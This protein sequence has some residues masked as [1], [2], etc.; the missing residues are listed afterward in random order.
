MTTNIYKSKKTKTMKKCF[1]L[2]AICAMT[3]NA[4]AQK[5][6]VLDSKL[7]D[8]WFVGIYGGESF[9]T[10][11]TSVFNNLN[12]VAGLRLG[13]YI[14]PVYGLAVDGTVYFDAAPD[15]HYVNNTNTFVK[16]TNISL[17]NNFN[18][19][20]L[21]CG[22]KGTPRF[23]EVVAF[24]G[25]G[26]GHGYTSGAAVYTHYSYNEAYQPVTTKRYQRN[27]DYNALTTKFGFDFNLNLGEAKA[28]QINIEPALTYAICADD[29]TNSALAKVDGV[30]A[31]KN[32][33]A[34][35]LNKSALSLTA[36]ITYKF[37]NS[38][39][40]HNF[41]LGTLRDQAEIDGLNAR[42]NDL[43]GQV[44]TKDNEISND[45][46]AINDLKRQLQDCEN[47]AP[48]KEV[49]TKE[50]LESVVTFKQGKT[51]IEVSQQPNVERIATYLKNHKD[52]KVVIKGYASPEGAKELNEKLASQRADAVKDMLVKKY[53]IN[54]SRIEAA[55][56]GIGDMF[57]EPDW[58]RVSICT[59]NAD[60]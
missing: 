38:N 58:N 29:N 25:A 22:Y 23:F 9:K 42:I 45:Q 7:T 26:W 55:G 31:G 34:F 12:T 51:N 52:S 46:K 17:L 33:P 13:R 8:N 60:K 24:A 14:T 19:S 32:Y 39:G 36:G 53:K 11:H 4:S 1:L 3:L 2:I 50:A 5:T 43:R 16:A 30:N 48:Q 18:L 27:P 6:T 40:T 37:G 20:N 59:I 21:F 47:R 56:N 57:T 35:N 28:W 49:K 41:V 54:A 15:H 10:T 44:S